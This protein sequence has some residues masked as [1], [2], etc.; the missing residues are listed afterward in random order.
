MSH[1]PHLYLYISTQY[2][3]KIEV[4]DYKLLGHFG[5]RN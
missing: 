1:L 4:V 3:L 5:L 2:I